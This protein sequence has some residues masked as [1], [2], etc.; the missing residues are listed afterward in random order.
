MDNEVKLVEHWRGLTPEKQQKVL[1]FVEIL[2][3]ESETTHLISASFIPQTLLG[4]KLWG[5][6]QRAISDGLKLLNEDEIELELVTRRGGS[7]ELCR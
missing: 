2:K 1:E 3:S 4:K 5:I 6:R 7:I